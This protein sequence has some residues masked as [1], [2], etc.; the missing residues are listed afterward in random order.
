MDE[1]C[2]CVEFTDAWPDCEASFAV[3]ARQALKR[4]LRAYGLRCVRIVEASQESQRDEVVS[5]RSPD[6]GDS[7]AM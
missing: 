4:C 3:R 2:L 7:G 5:E 1:N 6:V